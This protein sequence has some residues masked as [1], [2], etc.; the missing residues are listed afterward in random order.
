MA[1][2]GGGKYITFALLSTTQI[3]I[4]IENLLIFL[5]HSNFLLKNFP[6]LSFTQLS[7]IY[8]EE[9]LLPGLSTLFIV[10]FVRT[11]FFFS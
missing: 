10:P 8:I 4:K 7:I 5:G 3:A 11:V 6:F 1:G 9:F 2:G